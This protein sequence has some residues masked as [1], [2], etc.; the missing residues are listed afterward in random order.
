MNWLI[1]CIYRY[2]NFGSCWIDEM[3][4][5]KANKSFNVWNGITT[6]VSA[7]N[8]CFLQSTEMQKR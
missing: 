3:Y 4:F 5:F 2:L 8:Q 7:V 1:N 6:W